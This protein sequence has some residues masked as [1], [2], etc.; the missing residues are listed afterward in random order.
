[1]KSSLASFPPVEW[2]AQHGPRSLPPKDALERAGSALTDLYFSCPSIDE[3]IPAVL[4]Q[5]LDYTVQHLGLRVG[6]PPK[7][8]LAKICEGIADAL[9]M[10]GAAG[11][12]PFLAE[13]KLDGMRAQIHILSRPRPDAEHVEAESAVEAAPSERFVKIFSRN[14][15]DKTGMFPDVCSMILDATGP[16]VT[17]AILDTEVVG[18]ERVVESDES[19]HDACP[20]GGD[21]VV[22]KSR[23]LK[24]F[25]E[26]ATRPRGA[27]TEGQVEVPIAIFAFD[28]LLLNGENLCGRPL[29]ERRAALRGALRHLRYGFVE[30]AESEELGGARVSVSTA[31]ATAMA[32]LG[33]PSPEAAA[34]GDS[35]ASA[36]EGRVME[37][38][39]EA[40]EAG[41]E[42]LMLKSLASKYEA[43]K[44][45][46]HWVKIKRDYVSGIRDSLDLVPIGAW[47][48]NGRKAGWFSPFL[49]AAYDPDS[50]SF[51]SVC[52]CMS[53]FTDEFYRTTTAAYTAAGLKPSSEKPAYYSTNESCAVWFDPTEVWELRGADLT[54]STT[55]RAAAGL[56]HESRGI[57]LRFPR[58]I[59]ARPDKKPE[60]AT[61]PAE[62]VDMF[63]KQ[64]RKIEVGAGA[65]AGAG[66]GQVVGKAEQGTV[67]RHREEGS[68]ELESDSEARDPDE[69]ELEI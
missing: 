41:A 4:T 45:S 28:L 8:M 32:A 36:L 59:R 22:V 55:H 5:G 23:R 24:A 63:Q 9:K 11:G 13:H 27:V 42:G 56:L 6:T 10:V 64:S 69:P 20:A 66:G 47:Y 68:P 49:L 14:G 21:G 30:I 18:V 35:D 57:S 2:Q 12:G 3:I 44:R 38:L 51:Q 7:P 48:G 34:A 54:L 17:S 62:L 33:E 50:E 26:L 67:R 37:V 60:E 39:M 19:G 29:A 16:E 58:F 31:T 61:T 43:S 25:Q 1:M 65:G 15:E 53:G 52:R 46:E 40:L